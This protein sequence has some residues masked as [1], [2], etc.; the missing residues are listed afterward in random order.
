MPKPQ[1][2]IASPEL[3]PGKGLVIAKAPHQ[4]LG[5]SQQTFNRLV[6]KIE[7]LQKEINENNQILNQ[8]TGIRPPV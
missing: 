7:R 6:K 5:K 3:S 2:K 8:K 1:K 4:G